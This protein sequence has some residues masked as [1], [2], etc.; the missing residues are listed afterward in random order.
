MTA[1][2]TT[3]QITRPAPTVPSR[4]TVPAPRTPAAEEGTALLVALDEA[5]ELLAPVEPESLGRTARTALH[6]LS[7]LAHDA[8]AALG[9]GPAD[10]APVSAAP[11][12]GV[13]DLV[14]AARRLRRAV[15]GCPTSPQAATRSGRSHVAA[16]RRALP[17]G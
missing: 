15:E 14:D 7:R 5:V 13:R 12:V 8:A 6:A 1:M 4:R 2:T 17:T 3:T 16:L 11:V 10:P 9:A